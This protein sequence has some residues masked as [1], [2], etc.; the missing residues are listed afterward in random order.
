MTKT[1]LDMEPD[2]FTA[3]QENWPR[4]VSLWTRVRQLRRRLD[5][6]KE[7]TR[8]AREALADAEA[9]LAMLMNGLVEQ[10]DDDRDD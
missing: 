7:E 2:L 9:E 3:V 6:L 4:V 10:D 5:L 8:A 1:K